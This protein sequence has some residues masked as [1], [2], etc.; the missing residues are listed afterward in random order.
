MNLRAPYFHL[1]RSDLNNNKTLYIYVSLDDPETW[2]NK[3]FHNS[4]Y[5]ILSF[6]GNCIECISKHH[7]LPTFRKS[8]K[9]KSTNQVQDYINKYIGK[10]S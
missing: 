4:R 10:I 8:S 5:L 3:I 6:D 1:K 2:M 9:V 7:T